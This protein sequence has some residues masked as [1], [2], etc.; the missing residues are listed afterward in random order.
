MQI[1]NLSQKFSNGISMPFSK[2]FNQ[3][4][5]NLEDFDLR[6]KRTY[7][8]HVK[9]IITENNNL[10]KRDKDNEILTNYMIIK[11]KI[12]H[13][14]FKTPKDFTDYMIYNIFKPWFIEEIIAYVDEIYDKYS[15]N[16]DMKIDESK[17]QYN[18]TLVFKN[19]HCKELH[20]IATAFRFIIPLVTHFMK[21]YSD[22]VPGSDD[23]DSSTLLLVQNNIFNKAKFLVYIVTALINVLHNYNKSEPINIYSKL[24]NYILSLIRSTNYSDKDIW[25][26]LILLNLTTF[27]L[28]DNIMNKILTDVLPKS[29]FTE[30]II[31]FIVKVINKHI[32]FGLHQNFDFNYTSISPISDDG[33]FS[34]AD[35]FEINSAKI[36]ETRAIV[37]K[38]FINDTIIKLYQRKGYLYD[39]EEFRYYFNNL[40][41]HQI[42]MFCMLHYFSNAFGGVNNLYTCNK[43]NWINLLIYL[44]RFLE[45]NKFKYLQYI[46]TGN[47]ETYSEKRILNKPIERKLT[48]SLRYKNILQKYSNINTFMQKSYLIEKNLMI[49]LNSKIVYNHYD[50]EHNG[51][52]I[53]LDPNIICDEFLRFIELI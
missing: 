48:E 1:F 20:R 53:H 7:S 24:Y 51:E 6:S 30:N 31:G 9:F 26:K 50:Y 36:N 11:H 14:R 39:P 35:K 2:I 21:I 49:I 32:Y 18:E 13:E 38:V 28:A 17:R 23:E 27:S 33:D 29:K 12:D 34:D 19:I 47:I 15:V 10:I 41:I 37:Q 3:D 52:S 40:T 42:Q 43:E 44:I 5:S 45:N 8:N 25:D 46:L 4:L 22:M 16:V